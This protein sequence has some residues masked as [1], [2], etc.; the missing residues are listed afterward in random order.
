MKIRI[1]AESDVESL[2]R[3]RTSVHENHQSP[4]ELS[5]LRVTPESI[6]EMLRTTSRAW[7][8]EVG[9]QPAAFSMADGEQGTIFAMFVCP[10]YE[11]QGLGRALMDE[12]ESWLFSR[13]WKEIWLLTGG[14]RTLRA[15]GFYRHL[16]WNAVSI[17]T[18]GQLKYVKR[19]A[20]VIMA[21][22]HAA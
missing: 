4:E 17:E 21:A 9:D 12:A 8:A 10:G 5:A 19:R 22:E 2:F 6:A 11:G 20:G 13:K 7:L 3:I 14:D 15:N 18:D 16:G 1:A